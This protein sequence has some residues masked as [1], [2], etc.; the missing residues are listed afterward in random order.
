M[1]RNLRVAASLTFRFE[2]ISQSETDDDIDLRESDILPGERCVGCYIHAQRPGRRRACG[3]SQRMKMRATPP[4]PHAEDGPVAC[5]SAII[6]DSRGRVRRA[7]YVG[8]E[9]L[10]RELPASSRRVPAARVYPFFHLAGR[11]LFVRKG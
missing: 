8:V 6:K 11:Q 2:A 3:G 10:C 7:H 4:P 1:S 5:R 9:T